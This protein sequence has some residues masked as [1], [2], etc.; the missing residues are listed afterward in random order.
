M[1]K[2]D[3]SRD[4]VADLLHVSRHT[5]DAWLKPETSKSSNPAPLWAIELLIYK[6]G[7]VPP[8]YRP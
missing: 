2:H 8:V 3:L 1:V 4:H 7:G 6:T 5:V